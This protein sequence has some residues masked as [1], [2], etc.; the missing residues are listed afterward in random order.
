MPIFPSDLEVEIALKGCRRGLRVQEVPV[1][2]LTRQE[3]DSNVRVVRD[4]LA[5]LL[6]ATRFRLG[7]K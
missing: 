2:H 7:L 6:D 3:G 1:S 4:G 5:I